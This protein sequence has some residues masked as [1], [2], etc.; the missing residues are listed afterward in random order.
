[1]A[2][3]KNHRFHIQAYVQGAQHAARHGD[4]KMRFD[5][6]WGIGQQHGHG[7]IALDA[8]LAQCRC[9]LFATGKGIAPILAQ[10]AVNNGQMFAIHFGSAHQMVYWRELGVIGG[11]SGQMGIEI[12]HAVSLCR[13]I[14]FVIFLI[15]INIL[16]NVVNL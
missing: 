8:A 3:T 14:G 9:Q 16:S 1:M 11:L 7:V 13:S 15:L 5:H 4:A 10:I 12:C 6:G 2:Q